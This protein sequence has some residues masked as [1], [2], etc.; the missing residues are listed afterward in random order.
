M[1]D[2]PQV[3]RNLRVQSKPPL[4][5]LP[6]VTAAIA[7]AEATLGDHGRVL[8]RYSGT[9]PKARVMVEGES[10]ST[11]TRLADQIAAILTAAIGQQ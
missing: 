11:V 6:E 1:T 8:V 9:E 2:Y 5:E 3:L 7:D 10:E 4:K